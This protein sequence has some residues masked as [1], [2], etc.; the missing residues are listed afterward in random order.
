MSEKDPIAKEIK[1][2]ANFSVKFN[3]N[4]DTNDIN[5]IN[6]E[7]SSEDEKR[8]KIIEIE[9]KQIGDISYMVYKDYFVSGGSLYGAT[10]LFIMMISQVLL[11]YI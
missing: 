4:Q 2:K 1:N 3:Y 10:V 9:E 7:E 8:R 11:F 6:E 5:D